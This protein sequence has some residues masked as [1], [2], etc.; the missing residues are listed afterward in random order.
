M[1]NKIVTVVGGSGFV[2]RYI[3]KVLA[4]VGYTIRVIARNPDA[5]GH[6]K[7]AG[8]V[9]Q[10]VLVRGNLAR[11]ESLQGKLDNSFAVINLVGILFETINQ[12]FTSLHA[13]GA[14]KLAQL[15]KTAGAER[16]IHMSSIGMDNAIKSKYA[17]T[18]A[19]GEKAVQAAFPDAT[20]LRPSIVFG[21][22]DQFFN[23]FAAMAC[24]SPV[25]PAIGGGHTK[26]QPVYVG[27]VARAVAECLKTPLTRSSIFE[28]GGPDIFTFRQLLEYICVTTGRNPF[29]VNVP[30]GL[31]SFL[32]YFTQLLPHPLITHDQVALLEHDNVVGKEAKGF[33][34]LG[35]TPTAVESIVPEYLSRYRKPEFSHYGDLAQPE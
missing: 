4:Q 21:P 26:F 31:A 5:A 1:H 15:A 6:L 13:K 27:D 7:T 29:L 35:I 24:I 17:R 14:E 22:E 34:E 11:P 25:L 19:M 30:F 32:G 3:V 16:F 8:E 12:N 2:G 20:I 10:I 9:G 33:T 18:K 23:K 28:L